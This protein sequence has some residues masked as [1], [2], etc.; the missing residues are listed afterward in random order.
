[1]RGVAGDDG[2][3]AQP[4]PQYKL[5]ADKDY[6]WNFTVIPIKNNLEIYNHLTYQYLQ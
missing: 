6:Y 3:G 1:M 2:W 5:P 4:Y